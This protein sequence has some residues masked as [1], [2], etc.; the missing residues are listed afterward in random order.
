[1]E[2][3]AIMHSY[4]FAVD[5]PELVRRRLFVVSVDISG[6]GQVFFLTIKIVEIKYIIWYGLKR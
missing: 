4:C 1:L 5:F 3:V 2:I 6:A